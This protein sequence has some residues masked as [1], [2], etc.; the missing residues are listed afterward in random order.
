M[1]FRSKTSEWS[2]C[3]RDTR[4]VSLAPCVCG[5]DL[6]AAHG[7]VHAY[8]PASAACWEVFGRVQADELTHFGY[9]DAHGWVVDAYMA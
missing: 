8:V 2:T 6:P 1:L 3:A 4:A 7:P 9:P 5:L